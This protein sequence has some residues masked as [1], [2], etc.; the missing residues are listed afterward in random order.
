MRPDGAQ[1]KTMSVLLPEGYFSSQNGFLCTGTVGM[2]VIVALDPTQTNLIDRAQA[3]D[4]SAFDH[5]VESHRERLAAFVGK[6]MSRY[7][8]GRFE[9]EDV[10]QETFL[11]AFQSIAA[12]EERGPDSF[13]HWLRGIAENL[14][15]YW[16]REHHRTD[17]LP[18]L[19]DVQASA[20]SPSKDLRR[21]ERFDRLQRI[22][23]GFSSE[24]REVILLARVE[25]LPMKEVAVRLGRSPDAV[26]QILWRA[27]QKLRSSF[28]ET[29]SLSLPKDRRIVAGDGCEGDSH[30]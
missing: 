24:Q 23:A 21:E 15:L 13:L 29:E 19:A 30:E 28:G 1:R 4:R 11:K 6:R 12:F 18:L 22:L 5:L 2:K 17:Q 8:R 27:L 14:L 16:A 10:L 9:L 3:G 20:V 7:L 26:R 25:G